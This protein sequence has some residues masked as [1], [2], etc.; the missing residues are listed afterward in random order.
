MFF[1]TVTSAGGRVE[2]STAA[3]PVDGW[4]VSVSVDGV[5]VMAHRVIADSLHE[6]LCGAL[7]DYAGFEW[8]TADWL[9]SENWGITAPE[10]DEESE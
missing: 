9:V 5:Q 3:F 4:Q 8:D 10:Y 2:V 1:Q 7:T 6:V